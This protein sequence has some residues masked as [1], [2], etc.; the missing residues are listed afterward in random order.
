MQRH[1]SSQLSIPSPVGSTLA[2]SDNGKISYKRH[3]QQQQVN[4]KFSATN[5]LPIHEHHRPHDHHA[6]MA[7]IMPMSVEHRTMTLWKQ[8]NADYRNENADSEDEPY[9]P[10]NSYQPSNPVEQSIIHH[11]RL[12]EPIVRSNQNLLPR[13]TIT[14]HH[15]SY[16]SP[17]EHRWPQTLQPP[18]HPIVKPLL[19]LEQSLHYQKASHKEK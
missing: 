19:P 11:Y 2:H 16:H 4:P 17:Q 8:K 6:E 15:G 13:Q 7:H 9:I 12:Q 1:Q 18:L 14:S 3:R 5:L 10:P